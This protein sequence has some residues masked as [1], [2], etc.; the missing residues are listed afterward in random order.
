MAWFNLSDMNKILNRV[1][2]YVDARVTAMSDYN[3]LSNLPTLNGVEIKGEMSE[4]DPVYNEDLMSDSDVNTL[5]NN[6]FGSNS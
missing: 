2:S 6:I 5:L 4:V 3:N 1:K